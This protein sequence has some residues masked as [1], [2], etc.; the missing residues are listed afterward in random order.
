MALNFGISVLV[1]S[2]VSSSVI[3]TSIVGT[4]VNEHSK[5]SFTPAFS[6]AYYVC[7]NMSVK[8]KKRG[9][10]NEKRKERIA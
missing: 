6:N 3:S 5:N 8:R 9:K 10:Q 1:V 2:F 4:Y 7:Y